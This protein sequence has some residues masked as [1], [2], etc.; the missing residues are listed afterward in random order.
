[1]GGGRG[2]GGRRRGNEAVWWLSSTTSPP[3]GHC[4]S[5][6]VECNTKLGVLV[7]NCYYDNGLLHTTNVILAFSGFSMVHPRRC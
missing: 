7:L 3:L 2:D 1:M 5:S 6:S 4:N